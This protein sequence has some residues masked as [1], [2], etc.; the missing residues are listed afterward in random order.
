M[1]TFDILAHWLRENPPQTPV[2]Y[3]HLKRRAFETFGWPPSNRTLPI[4][5]REL[6]YL[7]H[8]N[9]FGTWYY[10]PGDTFPT[11]KEQADIYFNYPYPPTSP[12][13]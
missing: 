4:V 3:S 11:K 12:R 5:L 10:R 7:R 1:R 2:L 6:E 8:I 13:T 9:A